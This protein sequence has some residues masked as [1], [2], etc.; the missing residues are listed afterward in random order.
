[1][2]CCRRIQRSVMQTYVKVTKHAL[3]SLLTI[4]I[5]LYL[6]HR[7]LLIIRLEDVMVHKPWYVTK[8]LVKFRTS[9]KPAIDDRKAAKKTT[10]TSANKQSQTRKTG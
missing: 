1:L 6:T 10:Q 3:A 8:P 9:I 2:G 7:S 4:S 5:W